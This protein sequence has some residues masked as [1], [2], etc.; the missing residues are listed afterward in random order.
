MVVFDILVWTISFLP[1][2]STAFSTV[3][4]TVK[5]LEGKAEQNVVE[6]QM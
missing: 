2:K 3:M 6:L 5:A 4:G 1:P